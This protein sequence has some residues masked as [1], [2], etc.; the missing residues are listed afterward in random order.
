MRFLFYKN[1]W[2]SFFFLFL[3]F[4]NHLGTAENSHNFDPKSR[5]QNQ[6][7]C[8]FSVFSV[9]QKIVILK[10]RAFTLQ[11]FRTSKAWNTV[12]FIL[13]IE[14]RRIFNIFAKKTCI[15]LC[16][17]FYIFSVKLRFCPDF[18]WAPLFFLTH[19]WVS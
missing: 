4:S 2:I 8:A 19:F 18:H 15:P 11:N 10:L 14:I 1:F 12:Q 16:F 5:A 9:L 3:F 6:A 17:I 7:Y 13:G